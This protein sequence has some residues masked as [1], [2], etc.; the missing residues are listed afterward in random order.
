MKEITFEKTEQTPKAEKFN[1]SEIGAIKE[2]MVALCRKMKEAIDQGRY[3][4]LV[5]D[6]V[7]GRI[8][9]LILRKVMKKL[10]PNQELKTLFVAAGQKS[11]LPDYDR[12]EDKA[13]YKKL[14]KYLSVNQDDYVLLVTQFIY[15]G[16]T[17]QKLSVALRDAGYGLKGLDVA[18]TTAFHLSEEDLKKGV[19]T[20][21]DEDKMYRNRDVDDLR[22]PILVD[23]IFIGEISQSTQDMEKKHN[24]L[25]GVAKDRKYNPSPI[26]YTKALEEY[27]KDMNFF[28]DDELKKLF[29][30]E[31]KDSSEVIFNKKWTDPDNKRKYKE[32]ADKPLSDKEKEK[33]LED[34]KKAREDVETIASAILKE[35]WNL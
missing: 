2:D 30:I 3:T 1:F 35:V 27:G 31:E 26:L 23:N 9:T 8:P 18:A 5:S 10:H 29:G 32:L 19:V 22:K 34:I 24:R 28:S 16:Q 21:E 13:D 11:D 25:T 33:L 7:G 15:S 20:S 14:I 17:I 12:D 4:A 6:E